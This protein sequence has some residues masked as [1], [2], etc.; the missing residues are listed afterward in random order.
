MAEIGVVIPAYNAGHFLAETLESVVGQTW[1]DW[2]CVVVNDGSTDN[3]PGIIEQYAARDVRIR[4]VSQENR[5][6]A[7]ARNAGLAAL[8]PT[9]YVAFLD[10]DDVWEPCALTLL[11]D[12]LERSPAAGGAHGRVAIIDPAGERVQGPPYYRLEPRRDGVHLA[13]EDE[14]TT[15][16]MLTLRNV[17]WTPGA[18]LVRRAIIDTEAFDGRANPAEDWLFWMR[19]ATRAPLAFVNQ[20]VMRYRK[21]PANMSRDRARMDHGL[22]IA[23]QI[24]L[25]DR[26]L[27]DHARELLRCHFHYGLRLQRRRRYGRDSSLFLCWAMQSARHG[28]FVQAAK[29][30]RH[31]LIRGVKAHCP[32][33]PVPRVTWPTRA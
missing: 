27:D 3:T 18:A 9:R 28:H 25:A 2:T 33:I 26:S 31:A 19:I 1:R 32:A 30:T 22:A 24:M 20:P 21:H 23:R 7:K 11:R 29:Q 14:P 13:S 5:G 4:V 6:L 15:L 16:S 8:P 10:A 17:V 12:A